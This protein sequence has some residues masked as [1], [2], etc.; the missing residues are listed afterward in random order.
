[1]IDCHLDVTVNHTQQ[2]NDTN[3]AIQSFVI[4]EGR[5]IGP[6]WSTWW[7][8][9]WAGL[10]RFDSYEQIDSLD[11]IANAHMFSGISLNGVHRCMTSQPIDYSAW[12]KNYSK[13]HGKSQVLFWMLLYH[14]RCRTIFEIFVGSPLG[15]FFS[16]LI[17]IF[18]L[19][20]QLGN[21]ST[22][23]K[24]ALD[25]CG[26]NA[27]TIRYIITQGFTTPNNL[28]LATE[29]ELNSIAMLVARNAPRNMPKW[30]F[31]SWHWR[32]WRVFVFGRTRGN[33][34]DSKQTLRTS[35][36]PT[37]PRSL[38]S[39]MSVM[40]SRTLQR[41]KLHWSRTLWRSWLGEFSGM[42]FSRTIFARSWAL[43]RPPLLIWQGMLEPIQRSHLIAPTSVHQQPNTL[44][45]QLSSMNVTMTSTTLNSTAN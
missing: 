6:S 28:L 15:A 4:W 40:N 19:L 42:S 41:T 37:S 14:N 11:S 7:I 2:L 29:L 33:A 13:R 16:P 44:S 32:T 8:R 43:R 3:S 5:L 30:T 17:G 12:G 18:W 34:P 35:L 26:F 39:V 25:L 10:L 27:Q 31:H 24:D 1:M 38:R 21:R 23:I 36:Q 20:S 45:R 22:T 9:C